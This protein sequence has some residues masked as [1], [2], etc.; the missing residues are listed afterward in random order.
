MQFSPST[1]NLVQ[2]CS[3]S[4]PWGED[5]FVYVYNSRGREVKTYF[6]VNPCLQ[7]IAKYLQMQHVKKPWETYLK[8][9]LRHLQ[10]RTINDFSRPAANTDKLYMNIGNRDVIEVAHPQQSTQDAQ[11]DATDAGG[12]LTRVHLGPIGSGS[13]QIKSDTLRTEFSRT[14]GLL[15]TDIEMSSVL[16]SVIG[17]CRDSFILVKGKSEILLLNKKFCLV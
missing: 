10:E 17:N 2:F 16:D 3:H 13:D 1:V 5:Q 4:N 6:P 9:G 15:A 14:F 11:E 12:P 8:D 7:Q